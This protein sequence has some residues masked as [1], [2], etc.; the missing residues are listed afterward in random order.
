MSKIVCIMPVYNCDD[1][2]LESLKSIDGKVDEIH[3]CDGRWSGRD[4]PD[5]STDNTEQVIEAFAEHSKSKV[6][7]KCYPPMFEWEARNAMAK[8]VED[9]AWIIFLDSDEIIL[10]WLNVRETIEN[11]MEKAYRV[12]WGL[13]KT[14]A[15]VPNA[16][17]YRKTPTLYYNFNHREIFDKYGWIDTAR[18]PILHIV[19]VHQPKASSKKDREDMAKY[20]SRLFEYEQK[21]L[22]NQNC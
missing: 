4:G 7:Y 2:I 17:F 15:A 8:D 13:F 3:C 11:S 22:K 12:C 14:Y 19:Y 5:C 9:G 6:M 18:A 21:T 10:E 1:V 16:K 20:E